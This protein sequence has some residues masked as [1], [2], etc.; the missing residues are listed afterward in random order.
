MAGTEDAVAERNADL[1]ER[2]LLYVALT[3]AK[4]TATVTG[5]GT[6]SPLIAARG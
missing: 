5:W 6:L 1:I 4:K 2:S 3:R